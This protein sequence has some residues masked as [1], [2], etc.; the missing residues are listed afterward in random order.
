MIPNLDMPAHVPDKGITPTKGLVAQ[1]TLIGLSTSVGDHVLDE[2]TTTVEGFATIF[3][4][5][6]LLS[7]VDEEVSSEVTTPTK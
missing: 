1:I 7:R 6:I 3:A 2:I 4:C 5:M